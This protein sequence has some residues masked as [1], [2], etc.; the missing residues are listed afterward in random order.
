MKWRRKRA[1]IDAKKDGPCEDCGHRY[2]PFCMDLDHIDRSKKRFKLSDVRKFSFTA[3]REELAN[4][5]LL[6]CLCHRIRTFDVEMTL[7]EMGILM[8]S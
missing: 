1:L 6:C 3:I 7:G 2:P 5:R 8:E 4:T